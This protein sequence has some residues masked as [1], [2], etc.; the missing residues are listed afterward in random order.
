L[1][2]S[3]S[4]N[5][6]IYTSACPSEHLLLIGPFVHLT[7]SQ[8]VFLIVCLSAH[9]SVCLTIFLPVHQSICLSSICPSVNRAFSP[10][11]SKIILSIH[12]PAY[13]HDILPACLTSNQPACLCVHLSICPSVHIS[14]HPNIRL[15]KRSYAYI[16]VNIY[17]CL[18]TIRTS[19]SLSVCSLSLSVFPCRTNFEFKGFPWIDGMTES[20]H[21]KNN[22]DDDFFRKRSV[23]IGDWHTFSIICVLR[24]KKIFVF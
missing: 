18:S 10:S 23:Y 12:L 3:P 21:K 14:I 5:K 20:T 15:Y 11:A 1:S 16:P 8:Y 13:L 6:S 2:I 19:V 24:F 9:L 17:I 4:V 22:S 7:E